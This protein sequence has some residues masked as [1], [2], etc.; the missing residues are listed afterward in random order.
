VFKLRFPESHVSRWAERYSYPEDD[1]LRE[2][3]RPAVLARG[4]LR[5]SEFL[6]ICEWK[7]PRSKSRCARNEE[8]TIRTVSRAAFATA[9][10]SLKMDLLR[11]LVGVEWPTAS[12]LLHF[13]DVRPYPILDYRALWSLGHDRPPH[14]TMEFWLEYLAFT[15]RLAR[16]LRLDIRTLDRALWQ[17]SK[18]RQVD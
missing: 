4:F 6:R 17:F 18:A 14:Y 10:E 9:D 11:T 2:M 13:C 12:T 15:R 1:G 3:I 5:K 7:T 8:F 16:R